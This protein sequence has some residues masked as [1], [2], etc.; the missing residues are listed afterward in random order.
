[1][2][3]LLLLSSISAKGDGKKEL[4]VTQKKGLRIKQWTHVGALVHH[5]DG[6]WL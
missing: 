1:M 5:N 4:E 3:A 6:L 2:K